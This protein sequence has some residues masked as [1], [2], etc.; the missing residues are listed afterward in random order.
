MN[1]E[2]L[3]KIQELFFNKLESHFND[4]LIMFIRANPLDTGNDKFKNLIVSEGF[5]AKIFATVLTH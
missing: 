1:K 2:I 4:R 3:Q 5:N